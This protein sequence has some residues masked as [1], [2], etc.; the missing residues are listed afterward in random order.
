MR[1]Y[2]HFHF[3]LLWVCVNPP[4]WHH[5]AEQFFWWYTEHIFFRIKNHLVLTEIVKG[6]F[7]VVKQIPMFFSTSLPRHQYRHLKINSPDGSGW[8][9]QD[10]SMECVM[11]KGQIFQIE[12]HLNKGFPHDKISISE[13]EPFSKRNSNFLKDFIYF[14]LKWFLF[15]FI[16][17]LKWVYQVKNIYLVFKIHLFGLWIFS[18]ILLLFI[19][20]KIIQKNVNLV[21]ISK[22]YINL[23]GLSPWLHFSIFKPNPKIVYFWRVSKSYLIL[24]SLVLNP[25]VV[26]KV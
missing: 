6:I 18:N 14:H 12:A 9:S 2:M 4:G 22:P 15:E 17:N 1:A 19:S 10:D 11:H 13:C 26:C 8:L 23:F 5:V 16:F 3:H 7:E 24:I 25:K 20:L 21:W